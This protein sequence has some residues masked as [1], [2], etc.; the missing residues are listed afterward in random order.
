MNNDGFKPTPPQ[1]TQIL[2]AEIN[3]CLD[4]R[5]EADLEGWKLPSGVPQLTPANEKGGV[6]DFHF[7]DYVFRVFLAD[8]TPSP[9]RS[10]TASEIIA[11]SRPVVYRTIE[12]GEIVKILSKRKRTA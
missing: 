10:A 6:H 1:S 12:D 3:D 9:I 8:G 5:R 2:R 4:T 11:G 7:G